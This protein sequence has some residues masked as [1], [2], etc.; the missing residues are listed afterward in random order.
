M[1]GGGKRGNSNKVGRLN[2]VMSRK[3]SGDP[4]KYLTKPEDAHGGMS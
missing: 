1:S 2:E 3:W 4:E